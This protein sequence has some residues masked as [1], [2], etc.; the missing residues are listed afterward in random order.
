MLHCAQDTYRGRRI[1]PDGKKEGETEDQGEEHE[2]RGG[3][4]Q[5]SS[6]FLY[7][8]RPQLGSSFAKPHKLTLG[9]SILQSV[10]AT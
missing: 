10:Q 9:G 6:F 2:G 5:F 4:C 8:E 7:A 1:L 3:K